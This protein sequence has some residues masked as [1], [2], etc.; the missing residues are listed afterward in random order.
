ME[1]VLDEDARTFPVVRLWLGDGGR[2]CDGWWVMG[3]VRLSDWE[4]P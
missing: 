1:G 4:P 3:V 2:H